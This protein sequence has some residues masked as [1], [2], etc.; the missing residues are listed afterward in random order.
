VELLP[1]AEQLKIVLDVEPMHA[2][3]AEEWTFLTTLD[4]ALEL[5]RDLNSPSLK[6]VFDTYH[7][8]H[9]PEILAR[10]PEVARHVGIVHLGDGKCPPAR[11]QNRNRLGE[12]IIPLPCIIKGLKQAGYDGDYDVELIGEE[13]ENCD[14]AGLLE[15]AKQSY[16][17]LVLA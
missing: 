2:G 12:G 13:I 15:C 16:E 5:V 11:E 8:G 9:D 17:R 14:Y 10:I 6:L 7:L 1:L 3:C 4:E